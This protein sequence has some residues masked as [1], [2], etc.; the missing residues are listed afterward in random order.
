MGIEIKR[1]QTKLAVRKQ[2]HCIV[3]KFLFKHFLGHVQGPLYF[4]D[5]RTREVRLVR[6]H[7]NLHLSFIQP[8]VTESRTLNT[9]ATR[10]RKETFYIEVSLFSF[11]WKCHGGGSDIFP[12]SDVV[13]Q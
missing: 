5:I 1:G 3:V 4:I 12:N 8:T 11:V 7:S 6:T 2:N 10:S 13:F 9:A